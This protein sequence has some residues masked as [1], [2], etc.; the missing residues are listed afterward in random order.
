MARKR[1]K[2]SRRRIRLARQHGYS[3]PL[4]HAQNGKRIP[5]IVD[6]Q[7]VAV[8]VRIGSDLGIDL[9][10]KEQIPKLTN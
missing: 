2:G 10:F 6:G 1:N 4:T 5:I 3:G 9:T 8:V 7:Q